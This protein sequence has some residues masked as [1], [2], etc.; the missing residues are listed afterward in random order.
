MSY[1]TDPPK[2]GYSDSKYTLKL[3]KKHKKIKKYNLKFWKLKNRF[4]ETYN[5]QVIE[6]WPTK[7][8]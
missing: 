3:K 4:N 8:N 1:K 6:S 5:H 2:T 7:M